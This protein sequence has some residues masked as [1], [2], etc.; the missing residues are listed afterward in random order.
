MKEDDKCDNKHFKKM[1]KLVKRNYLKLKALELT[2]PKLRKNIVRAAD[3]DFIDCI[4]ECC[5]NVLKGDVS[6]TPKRKNPYFLTS[7]NYEHSLQSRLACRKKKANNSNGWFFGNFVDSSPV[8]SRRNVV[9]EI[10][11]N[12]AKKMML[13]Y[14]R[15]V[16]N[17]QRPLTKGR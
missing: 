10:A 1:S 6:L 5:R 16:D 4:S 12:F 14:P 9:V 15:F 8:V 7:L 13:V 2:T 11:W 3:K 17:F